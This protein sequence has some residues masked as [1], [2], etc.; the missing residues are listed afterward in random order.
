MTPKVEKLLNGFLLSEGPNWDHNTQSLYFVDVTASTIHKYVPRENKHTQARIGNYN[1]SIIIPIKDKKNNFLVTLDRSVALIEWD[2]ESEEVTA[3]QKLCTVEENTVHVF[4][5]GKCDKTGR[6]W[7]GTMSKSAATV[8][9]IE[10]NQGAL[11]SFYNNTIN[12]HRHN[13][14]VSNGIAFDYVREKMYYIDS[15]RYSIDQYDINFEKGTL[16]NQKTIFKNENKDILC[17]GMTIDTDGNLWVAMFGAAAVYNIDPRTGNI[18]RTIKIPADQITSVSFGGPNLD[19]LYVTSGS[20]IDRSF[21]QWPGSIFRVT[22]L[23]VKGFQADEA[24]I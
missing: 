14:G 4:N 11:Y 5:D 2:G 1:V 8:D 6:L 12:T 3:I 19:E 24:V 22:G 9:G 23:N 13:V 21:G 18:L 16:S 7:L 20:I 17:D 10:D 15:Y